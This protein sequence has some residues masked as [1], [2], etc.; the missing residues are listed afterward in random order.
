M[1]EPLQTRQILL[2][3]DDIDDIIL[4][5]DAFAQLQLPGMITVIY[6]GEKLMYFLNKTASLPDVLCLDLNMPRK[7]GPDCLAEIKQS[8][9]LQSIPIVIFSTSYKVS[10]VDKLYANGAQYY[11]C[12]PNDFAILKNIILRVLTLTSSVNLSQ[13]PRDQFVLL[14]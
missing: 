13:P 7:N 4:F 11:I 2:A 6:D 5:Q 10:V 9:K 12:K 1:V 3:D 8:K 14:F